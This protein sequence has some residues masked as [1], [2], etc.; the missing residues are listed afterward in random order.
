MRRERVIPGPDVWLAQ[1][2]EARAVARGGVVR[3][4][5]RDIERHVG[6]ERLVAEVK[7]R[8]FH[9]VKTGD[10]VLILCHSGHFRVIC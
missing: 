2:F 8:G 10:Q 7:R 4:Q 9:L 5:R 3:R 6:W 1:I